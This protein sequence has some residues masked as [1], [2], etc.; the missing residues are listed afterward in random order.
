M[1]QVRRVEA[2]GA[3]QLGGGRGRDVFGHTVATSLFR[4]ETRAVANSSSSGLGRR[5]TAR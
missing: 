3:A 1:A 2:V 4:S 5:G